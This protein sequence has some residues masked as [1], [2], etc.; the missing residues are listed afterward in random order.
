[1][2]DSKTRISALVFQ[3]LCVNL[4]LPAIS[5]VGGSLSLF[6]VFSFL[7]RKFGL[8]LAVLCAGIWARVIRY[9]TP[10]ALKNRFCVEKGVGEVIPP[11]PPFLSGAPHLARSFIFPLRWLRLVLLSGR[12]R[13]NS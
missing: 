3:V 8:F 5:C 13:Y 1:M 7:Y 9:I 10:T 6:S 4:F 2:S 11:T 12:F